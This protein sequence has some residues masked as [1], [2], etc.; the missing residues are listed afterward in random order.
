MIRRVTVLFL[1]VAMILACIGS[2]SGEAAITLEDFLAQS[3]SAWIPAGKKEYTVQ[4]M[5]VSKDISFHNELEVTDYTVTDDGVTVVLKGSL[6][7]M[8]ASKLSKVISAYTKPDGSELSEK[9][10]AVKDTYIDILTRPE[11]DAYFVM[12]VPADIRVTVKTAWGDELHTNLPNAPHGNGDYLVC[13]K[14]P[15]GKP[16]LS[17]VW[18]LNGM[19][20]PEYYQTGAVSA[21]AAPESTPELTLKQ[22]VV[23]SRHNIRA[24]LAGPGSILSSVTPHKW[25]DF[26]ANTSELTVRGGAMENIMGMW[27]R[28]WLNAEGLLPENTRPAKGEIRFYANSLQ[29]TIATARSFSAGFLPVANTE[30]ETHVDY[31]TMDPVF[32]PQLTYVSD[33]YREAVAED[34]ARIY[35]VDDVSRIGER[36]QDAYA[37]LADLIDLKESQAYAD[38]TVTGFATDDSVFILEEGQE[39]GVDGSLKLGC[40]IADALVLQYYEVADDTRAGFGKKVSAEDMRLVSTIKDTYQDVLFA[41]PLIAVNVAHPMLKEIAAELNTEG[42]IF[43]FLCGHDSNLASVMAALACKPDETIGSIE[44]SIPIGSKLLFEKWADPEGT[45]YARL[46]LVYASTEQLRNLT[47]LDDENP[48]VSLTLQFRDLPADA[49]GY[50]LFDELMTR[51]ENAI[52]AYDSLPGLYDDVLENAA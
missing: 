39:P 20:F 3:N 21:E 1:T 4:A 26:T 13:R 51:L 8:W 15:D 12:H 7:E 28:K 5:M 36:L 31:N 40:R 41:V 50:Y 16:D 2:G 22:V 46:R 37:Y 47:L 9:D 45:L 34:T 27:F 48:P 30:I 19:I 43:T 18:V 44:P 6:G 52:D 29:R 23:L 32:N 38:G 24:P 10:F 49:N 14:A 17:D 11:P 33:A 35:G 25:I 42:R